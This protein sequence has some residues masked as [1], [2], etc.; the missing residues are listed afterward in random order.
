MSDQQKKQIA[1]K[2]VQA[3]V[4][5]IPE[6]WVVRAQQGDKQ[7][8]TK[9]EKKLRENLVAKILA[10]IESHQPVAQRGF[11][12][13]VT[14]EE[15]DRRLGEVD[16]PSDDVPL[17]IRLGAIPLISA[18]AA[19]PPRNIRMFVDECG[20]FLAAERSNEE[21]ED[22]LRWLLMKQVEEA[23][24]R[25]EVGLSREKQEIRNAVKK[26]QEEFIEVQERFAKKMRNQVTAYSMLEWAIALDDEAQALV[27]D[28][29]I[30]EV[31]KQGMQR[32]NAERIIAEGWLNRLEKNKQQH[33]PSPQDAD[34]GLKRVPQRWNKHALNYMRE[35]RPGHAKMSK[36]RRDLIA[37]QDFGDDDSSWDENLRA[38]QAEWNAV[39]DDDP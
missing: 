35:R 19:I 2:W 38:A 6:V 8:Q 23:L 28:L 5:V 25:S 7:A 34:Q 11:G 16:Y 4:K 26:T 18:P 24:T 31:I 22:Q 32:A 36:N 37:R 14:D 17:E 3:T 10:A 21:W 33:M 15:L 1:E 27:Q 29:K 9:G 13:P 12:F 20:H 30:R 39:R